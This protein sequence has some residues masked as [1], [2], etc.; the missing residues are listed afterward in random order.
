MTRELLE[1][2]GTGSSLARNSDQVDFVAFQSKAVS[3]LPALRCHGCYATIYAVPE[4]L[5]CSQVPMFDDRTL[6]NW[7]ATRFGISAAAEPM[8]PTLSRL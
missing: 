3:P 4:V 8:L 7:L 1:N 6:V 5:S 2:Y